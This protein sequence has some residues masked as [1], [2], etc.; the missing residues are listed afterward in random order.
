M[1]S[2]PRSS[3]YRATPHAPLEEGERNS[4][5][6]RLNAAYESGEVGSDDYHRLLDV[7][8]GATTLGQVA[9][10]VEALPGAATHDTPAI[11][12]VGQGRPGELSEARRP[13]LSTAV[14]TFAVAGV[15]LMV[16]IIVVLGVIGGL[17]F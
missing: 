17:F 10:V 5:V 9:E 11:V 8:F 2:L 13:S 16:L 14:L 1:A 6:E 15:G 4:L 12:P 7:A 3:K